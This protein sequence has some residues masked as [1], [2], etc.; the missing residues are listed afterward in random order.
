MEG[1][2]LKGFNQA[3]LLGGIALEACEHGL[4]FQAVSERSAFVLEIETGG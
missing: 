2:G 4:A 3:A 1:F